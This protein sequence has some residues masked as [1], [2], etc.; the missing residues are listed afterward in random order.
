M[1]HRAFS[2]INNLRRKEMKKL[3]ANT[4]IAII[5][6]QGLSSLVF[7][8]IPTE[9]PVQIKSLINL[10]GA[11]KCLDVAGGQTGPGTPI[12]QY[13]CHNGQN[14]RFLFQRVQSQYIIKSALDQSMCVGIPDNVHA[15]SYELLRL[16]PCRLDNAPYYDI[17]LGVRW[18]INQNLYGTQLQF[19]AVSPSWDHVNTCIDV[20]GGSNE[21]SLWLQLYYCHAGNNQWWYLH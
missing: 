3:I 21:N 13:D 17:P 8:T 11:G 9:T 15:S 2:E 12:V 14:Q 10:V 4:F 6:V 5:V 20:T 1:P 7:A 16:E 18:T 19:Q